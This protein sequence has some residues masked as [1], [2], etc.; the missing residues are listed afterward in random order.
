MKAIKIY[1]FGIYRFQILKITWF[2]FSWRRQRSLVVMIVFKFPSLSSFPLKLLKHVISSYVTR[3]RQ[4]SSRP[5]YNSTA[6]DCCCF[7]EDVWP[8][9]KFDG[10]TLLPAREQLAQIVATTRTISGIM[11]TVLLCN[12]I[13]GGNPFCEH[14]K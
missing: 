14:V 3:F 2:V 5:W 1:R 8:T 9:I 13:Y 10:R 11:V 7:L 12:Y 6:G 4:R